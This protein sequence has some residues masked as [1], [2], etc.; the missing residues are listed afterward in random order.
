MTQK[1]NVISVYLKQ[2]Q[3]LFQRYGYKK[4]TMDDIA[5]SCGVAKSTL[6]HYF[7]GKDD[8]FMQVV[9][10][11]MTDLRK[12]VQAK[13]S[14]GKTVQQKIRNYFQVFH[15]EV[16]EKRNLYR[17]LSSELRDG[18]FL[19]Q[20]FYTLMSYEKIYVAGLLRKAY[21]NGELQAPNDNNSNVELMA[22]VLLAAF[23]GILRYSINTPEGY[24]MP[25]VEKMLGQLIPQL[26]A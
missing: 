3:D 16:L 13:V 4:T 14:Q 23:Y 7:S 2:A 25:K 11:E 1:S 6:Y 12:L 20:Q 24:D 5:E 9:E 15:Q 10:L 26:F 18:K 22:E 8:V 19:Y 21:D 17:I